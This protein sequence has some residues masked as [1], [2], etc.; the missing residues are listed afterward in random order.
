MTHIFLSRVLASPDT[1]GKR[2]LQTATE[3]S[4]L[5]VIIINK[6]LIMVKLLFTQSRRSSTH[7][8]RLIPYTDSSPYI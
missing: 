7:L 1:L 5:I 3:M 4:L 6:L 8:E 2:T